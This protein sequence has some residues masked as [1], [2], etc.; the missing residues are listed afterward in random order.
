MEFEVEVVLE[1]RFVGVPCTDL[2]LPLVLLAT[3]RDGAGESESDPSSSSSGSGESRKDLV[4]V[5]FESLE[6]A[7]A[8]AGSDRRVDRARGDC[9]IFLAVT[10]TVH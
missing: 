4:D 5:D 9:D 7:C 3:A 10:D 2:I 1:Y 6:G 8:N